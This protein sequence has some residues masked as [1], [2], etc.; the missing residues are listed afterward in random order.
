MGTLLWGTDIWANLSKRQD[1][2]I[3]QKKQEKSLS[4]KGEKLCK[5]P[6]AE[7]KWYFEEVKAEV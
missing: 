4:S 1:K 5:C 7:G 6:V 3:F 2:T